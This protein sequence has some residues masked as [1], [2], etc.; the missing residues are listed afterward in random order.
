MNRR[1]YLIAFGAAGACG[2]AGCNAFG[3]STTSSSATPRPTLVNGPAQ[4]TNFEIETAGDTTVDKTVPV[5]V[6]AFNYGTQSGDFSGIITAVEGA[7]RVSKRVEL[8]DVKSG[9]RAETT[10]DL[11][12]AI[13]DEYVLGIFNAAAMPTVTETETWGT[14]TGTRTLSAE[15]DATTRLA[16]G[17]QTAPVGKPFELTSSLRV[18]LTDVEYRQG[19]YYHRSLG[20]GEE[21]TDLYS[22][23]SDKTLALLRFEVE[24]TGSEG[25]SFGPEP[26]TVSDGVL[27]TDIREHSL[28]SIIDIEGNPFVGTG[29]QSGVVV[30]AG[31][32]IRGWFLAHVSKKQAKE[33][34]VIGWQRDAHKTTPERAWTVEPTQLPSFSLEKWSLDTE[35]VPGKYPH[36]IS[37]KNAGAAKGTFRGILENKRTDEGQN[38]WSPFKTFSGSIPPGKSKTFEITS[39]WPYINSLEYRVR[40]FD[41]TRSVTFQIPKLSFGEKVTTPGGAVRVSKV[42]TSPSYKIEADYTDTGTKTYKPEDGAAFV[43]AYVEFIPGSGDSTLMPNQEHFSLRAKGETYPES[44]SLSGPMIAPVSGRFYEKTYD[45]NVIRAGKPWAG[46]VS[47][48]VPASVNVSD[49][50]VV[51]EKKYHGDGLISTAEWSKK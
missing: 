14:E 17:P 8:T 15:P 18:T 34:T 47:F 37:I 5:T 38:A 26:F 51:M 22:T 29:Y 32:R 43:F 31:Q 44:G 45:E 28:D 10:V 48:D 2:L 20:W 42:Q 3:G 16:V 27:Y 46:W 49:V 19:V 40:P 36:R 9:R 23:S 7:G 33:G 30:K 4:F 25:V 24:N 12:I 1:E 39:S 35:Q 41:T 50:T 13:A 11:S 21:T 6:S